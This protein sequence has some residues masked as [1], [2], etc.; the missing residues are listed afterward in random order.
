MIE[1]FNPRFVIEAYN[2]KAAEK[3]SRTQNWGLAC[4][5]PEFIEFIRKSEK[6]LNDLLAIDEQMDQYSETNSRAHILNTA[7][8]RFGKVNDEKANATAQ[9]AQQIEACKRIQ[10]EKHWHVQLA[11]PA[12]WTSMGDDKR[13]IDF[14][15]E[16]IALKKMWQYPALHRTPHGL[17][18]RLILIANHTLPQLRLALQKIEQCKKIPTDISLHLKR[19]LQQLIEHFSQIKQHALFSIDARFQ[20]AHELMS[21]RSDL[22]GDVVA[23]TVMCLEKLAQIPE[24][25]AQFFPQKPLSKTDFQQFKQDIEGNVKPELGKK[26]AEQWAGTTLGS[27]LQKS[28]DRVIQY[29]GEYLVI[30]QHL[31]IHMPNWAGWPAWFFA[32][33]HACIQFFKDKQFAFVRLKQPL[34]DVPLCDDMK[35][36]EKFLRRLDQHEAFG[37]AEQKQIGQIA[38]SFL[39]RSYGHLLKAWQSKLKA[40]QNRCVLQRLNY[41]E[42]LIHLPL[43]KDFAQLQR[44]E[45]LIRILLIKLDA[46]EIPPEAID[47]Y[48]RLKD[49]WAENGE[50][51]F[52]I[53]SNLIE[54]LA[55]GDVPLRGLDLK[56]L[57]EA[58]E[59]LHVSS[60]LDALAD[61]D[62]KNA[63]VD[64]ACTILKKCAVRPIRLTDYDI[65][66]RYGKIARFLS[67]GAAQSRLD[68]W[69]E[70]LVM[71]QMWLWEGMNEE[72]AYA[73][74]ERVENLIQ[75]LGSPTLNKQLAL[76]HATEKNVKTYQ[77]VYSQIVRSCTGAHMD[78]YVEH[79]MR[80]IKMHF[81]HQ[82]KKIT[83]HFPMLQKA[84]ESLPNCM[85]K[86]G[87]TQV[88]LLSAINPARLALETWEAT[89][90]GRAHP[91][92]R[93]LIEFQA[94]ARMVVDRLKKATTAAEKAE[95]LAGLRHAADAENLHV[96]GQ[97]FPSA[98][99]RVDINLPVPTEQRL[100]E[101]EVTASLTTAATL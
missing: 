25:S 86:Q 67:D 49:K 23:Y 43:P 41:L 13:N 77:R 7:V 79:E 81:T 58:L 52:I 95:L 40:H 8:H 34:P 57:D 71:H 61:T 80:R 94:K 84:L 65:F 69:L 19:Q 22:S 87:I 29:E 15:P 20:V 21:T 93:A 12:N 59:T 54:Q 73:A 64:Q 33:R 45:R 89:Q 56:M 6:Y 70:S 44:R 9:I 75:Q 28:H 62:T 100:A 42:Q 50:S 48:Q 31:Q 55:D 39:Q 26:I 91:E 51:P 83:K 1:T 46:Y 85:A 17:L 74:M 35:E 98:E 68:T 11:D 92:I 88:D 97:R 36:A 14:P 101:F 37:I 16:L 99:T 47:R 27:N 72:G 18:S 24:G 30:P 96:F 76:L 3:I 32:G 82:L 10:W 63:A 38:I 2:K 4:L 5:K 60:G 66:I 53:I 90:V 78:K